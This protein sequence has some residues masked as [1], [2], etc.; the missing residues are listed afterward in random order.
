MSEFEIGRMKGC[1]IEV[2][3]QECYRFDD[4]SVSWKTNVTCTSGV[5]NGSVIMVS[6]DTTG[7]SGDDKTINMCELQVISCSDDYWDSGCDRRCGSCSN[8]EVCDKVTGHCSSC[9]PGI[10]PPLCDTECETGT[11]GHNCTQTCSAGCEDVCDKVSGHCTCKPGWL[12]PACDAGDSCALGSRLEKEDDTRNVKLGPMDT[13]VHRLAVQDVRMSVT[14]SQDTAR[15]NLDGW[16]LLVM[17][18][19]KLGPMDTTVHRLA[20]QDVR[21]SVTRSQ[22]TA[23]ANLDGWGLLVVLNVKLG[24]M[25]TTVHRLAVQDVRMSVTRSQDTARANL[26][27]WGLLV[28]LLICTMKCETGTYGH[29]CT[30]TCSAGCEDVCDK[31][32]GH[33]TCKPGW[34]GPACDAVCPGRTYGLNCMHN[35]SAH[36]NGTCDKA[37]GHCACN[38]GYIPPLCLTEILSDKME[39]QFTIIGGAVGGS[40]VVLVV[41]IIIVVIVVRRRRNRP[42]ATGKKEN[43]AQEESPTLQVN[44]HQNVSDA[45]NGNMGNLVRDN[46]QQGA[47]LDSARI[48]SSKYQRNPVTLSTSQSDNVYEAVV[49]EVNHGYVNSQQ[50]MSATTQNPAERSQVTAEQAYIVEGKSSIEAAREASALPTDQPYE[51]VDRDREN[52]Y[53][54]PRMYMKTGDHHVY[55]D[56]KP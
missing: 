9:P 24:P 41:I 56:L 34:L 50:A 43:S 48:L 13:T 32:S 52:T 19:V 30:Q 11:Y 17:L 3:G 5:L 28:M 53:E 55:S 33:C 29:N 2:D 31:V 16:G 45:T 7:F 36:C 15:A 10:K 12:G 4:A 38:R 35:C 22:D 18:N 20:V 47:R 54:K 42:K 25:D 40:V 8:G 46:D 37:T 49:G 27:G 1:L 23:R 14:R 26:D 39:A 21:M 6:K 44:I 51:V